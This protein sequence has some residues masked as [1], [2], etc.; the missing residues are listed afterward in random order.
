VVRR[1]PEKIPC[2]LKKFTAVE[3]SF[4]IRFKDLSILTHLVRSLALTAAQKKD[5]SLPGHYVVSTAKIGGSRAKQSL[6]LNME[7]LRSSET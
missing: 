3:D 2:P 6:I 4:P 1:A 5:S 7:A